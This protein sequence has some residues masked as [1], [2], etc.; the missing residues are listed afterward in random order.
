MRMAP[1]TGKAMAL[2]AWT[3]TLWCC[4]EKG[5]PAAGVGDSGGIAMAPPPTLAPGELRQDPLQQ[6]KAGST[7]LFE[8]VPAV[9]AG[10]DFEHRWA[11]RSE[12]ERERI[13][14][15][16][17]G[18]GVALG[19]I[20]NDGLPEIFLT[21]P[22]GGSRLYRN[23]GAFRFKDI[24]ATMGLE[25]PLADHWSISATFVD[26]QG[27]GYL[28]LYVCGYK[29]KNRLFVNTG[30][31]HFEERADD[32]G[33]AFSGASLM[34][35]FADYDRDG[36]LDA[37]LLTN[38]LFGQG[39]PEQL[40]FKVLPGGEVVVPEPYRDELGAMLKPDGSLHQFNAGQR[41]VLYRNDNGRF[42]DTGESAGIR[43][44]HE[45]LS[46]TWWDYDGDG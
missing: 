19:D 13:S 44:H 21:R 17:S 34:M 24:T 1:V 3:A 31:G 12:E 18:G 45:G 5:Q 9:E 35:S 16:F 15:S 22:H 4:E 7:S 36:D 8:R 33:L 46:A 10:L 29:S 25:Q 39:R 41:D 11:P 38:R 43:G 6:R 23:L 40:D 42:V 28:D 2:A 37:Y 14:S 27:D 26:I 20:D 30:K 32:F